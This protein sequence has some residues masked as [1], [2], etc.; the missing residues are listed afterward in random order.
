MLDPKDI[1]ILK[2][3][4]YDSRTS[5]SD[6]STSIGL[7]VNAVKSRI[8]DI[9]ASKAIGNFL[10]IPNFAIFGFKISYSLLIK[11]DGDSDDFVSRLSSLGYVYMQID[12]FDDTSL[13]RV[14]LKNEMDMSTDMVTKLVKPHEIM[15]TFN[16]RLHSDFIPLQTDY[17]IIKCLVLEPRI[18]IIDLARKISMSEKTVIR[19]LEMMLKNRILDFTVQYNP[20]AMTHYLYSRIIVIV[21]QPLHNNVM[22]QIFAQFKDHFLCPVP[23]SSEHMI[24][25][26]LYAKNIPEIELVKKKIRSIKGVIHVVSRMPVRTTFNQKYLIKEI[27]KKIKSYGHATVDSKE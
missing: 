25:L 15:R 16:E 12:F 3:L 11:H 24:S 4:T 17:K 1:E 13:L 10:T 19:R 20:A 21:E 8:K 6:M 22:K 26:I 27:D 5:Y 18:R 7:T 2:I 23:P 14:L 9:L